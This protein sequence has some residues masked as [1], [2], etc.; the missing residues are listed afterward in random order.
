MK[1][2]VRISCG[3]P[4][5][6][7]YANMMIEIFKACGV[8]YGVTDVSCHRDAGEWEGKGFKKQVLSYREPIIV[9]IG[10]HAFHKPGAIEALYV[11][12]GRLNQLV[13]GVPID[14]TANN[15]IQ[16]LPFGTAVGTV[17]LNPEHTPSSVKN[18]ALHIVRLLAQ[19]DI[20]I[21]K[22]LQLYYDELSL[23]KPLVP[24][25]ELDE[26]GYIPIAEKKE[27]K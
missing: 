26:K 4:S 5:D 19:G 8:T 21:L 1:K 11:R 13:I 10:G 16:G 22:K 20:E 24:E 2:N 25:V 18:A 17:G 23:K 15:S 12:R 14:Q 27:G 3:S 6:H 9:A 7:P